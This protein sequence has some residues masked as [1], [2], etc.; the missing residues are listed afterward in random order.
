[1][2]SFWPATKLIVARATD[3][4]SLSSLCVMSHLDCSDYNHCNQARGGGMIRLEGV[5]PGQKGRY[6]QAGGGVA[7]EQLVLCLMFEP[8]YK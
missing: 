5:W 7:R 4:M 1:M 3:H 6:D 2:V 8:K